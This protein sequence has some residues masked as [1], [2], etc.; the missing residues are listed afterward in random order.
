MQ[1]E[2]NVLLR[3]IAEAAE[4]ILAFTR[5]RTQSE[6]HRDDM[7]SS[8]VERKFVI[9][10]E[11]LRGAI[12]ADGNVERSITQARQIIAFRN[13][14]VHNYAAIDSERVWEFIQTKLPLLLA[15]VQGLLPS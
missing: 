12:Q 8:A 9:I 11:A 15:K 4:A 1:R 2:V 5:G 10:G 14:L 3:D 13:L 6:L 7:L